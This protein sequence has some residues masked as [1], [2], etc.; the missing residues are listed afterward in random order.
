MEVIEY[1]H[2]YVLVSGVGYLTST[3]VEYQTHF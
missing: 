1:R 3:R 2:I